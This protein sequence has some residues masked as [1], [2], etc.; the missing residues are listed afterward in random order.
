MNSDPFLNPVLFGESVVDDQGNSRPANLPPAK[1]KSGFWQAPRDALSLDQNVNEFIDHGDP[2]RGAGKKKRPKPVDHNTRT[3]ELIEKWGY[4]G[5]KE[6][7]WRQFPSGFSCKVD[8]YGLWDWSGAKN[9]RPLLYVQV[10]TGE[11]GLKTHLREMTSDKKALDNRKPKVS[12]L[13]WCLE[14]GY[15]LAVVVWTK[16]PN[17]RWSG[18]QPESPRVVKITREL[19]DQ[20]ISRKRK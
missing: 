14:Q 16:Q 3:R 10:V 17:G 7:T 8:K 11:N 9:G 4:A 19:V 13:L 15:S 1:S 12:N 20:Y 5:T 18:D 2:E 6:E